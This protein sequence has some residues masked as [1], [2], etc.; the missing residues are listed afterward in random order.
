[1][2]VLMLLSTALVTGP[3]EL[4]LDD[5]KGLRRGRPHGGL[6]ARHQAP[7]RLPAGGPVRGF[8]VLEDVVLCRKSTP[9]EMARD[10]AGCAGGWGA[11]TS[12]NCRFSHDHSLALLACQ[13]LR[14]RPAL[15]RHRR[16]RPTPNAAGP[17]ARGRLP[18][19]A[20]R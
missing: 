7:G 2:R 18:R 19:L 13:R 10:L 5:A 16:G 15:V 12:C 3:A 1:V 9:V 11:R 4:C 17:A 20:T 8:E 6:R 14:E